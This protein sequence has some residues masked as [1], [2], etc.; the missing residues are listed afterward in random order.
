MPRGYSTLF[1]QEVEA[2]DQTLLGVQLARVCIRLQIPVREVADKFGVTRVTVY[3][4]FR[5]K[6]ALRNPEYAALARELLDTLKG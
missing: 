2:A 5:G 4:W 3:S 1:V 6:Y